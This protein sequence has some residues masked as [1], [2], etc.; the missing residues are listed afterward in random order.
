M[1]QPRQTKTHTDHSDRPAKRRPAT[2]LPVSHEKERAASQLHHTCHQAV[3]GANVARRT[4]RVGGWAATRGEVMPHDEQRQRTT[5]IGRGER[6][7][8]GRLRNTDRDH[9][10]SGFQTP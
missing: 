8:G 6:L 2:N 4:G 3:S 1:T 7:Y 5:G 9:P 10:G